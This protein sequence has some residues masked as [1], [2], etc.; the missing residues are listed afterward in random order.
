MSVV[1]WLITKQLIISREPVVKQR[2]SIDFTQLT[3]DQ[4]GQ[5]L[6]PY[7]GHLQPA[8]NHDLV[9][10]HAFSSHVH[11]QRLFQLVRVQCALSSAA[12]VTRGTQPA[13]Q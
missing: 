11:L 3:V 5:V 2:V 10:V 12:L 13:P 8:H 6:L 4:R 9:S 1:W 7:L